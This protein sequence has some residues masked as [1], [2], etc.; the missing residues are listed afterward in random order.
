MVKRL[1]SKTYNYDFNTENGFF[2]RWGKTLKDDPD[3]SPV[4]P[5]ICDMEISTICG[6]G[7]KF[8]YKGNT[9][10]G[11]NMSFDTFKKVFHKLPKTITQIAF[12]IGDI[13]SHP[14]LWKI[15]AYSRE[16]GVIPNVTVNGLHGSEENCSNLARLCGAVAVSHYDSEECF[17]TVRMLSDQVG[18]PGNTI[19]QT[20]IHKL[21]SEESYQDCLDLIE[22]RLSYKRLENLNAIVFLMLKPKGRGIHYHPLRDRNKYKALID[23][24]LKR[25]VGIG[26][27]SCSAFSFLKSVDNPEFHEK[28]VDSCES[29]CFSSYINVDARYFHCSFTEGQDG[30]DGIDVL[31][32]DDFVKDLWYHP[33][34]KRFRENSIKNKR[35]QRACQLFDLDLER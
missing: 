30:W 27:D 2:A 17:N 9:A 24:A 25:E 13:N 14:D 32:C 19:K 4:G 6:Q 29:D 12:G 8:C 5:E 26:F 28:F 31:G 22:K 18:L 34:V 21:L 1:R 16:N 7:C 33:E 10:Q 23:Y 20:N 11:K 3:F 35:Q 15:M